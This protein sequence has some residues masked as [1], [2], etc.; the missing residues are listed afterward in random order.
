MEGAERNSALLPEYSQ[1]FVGFTHPEVL[2]LLGY[3]RGEHWGRTEEQGE[4][5][6]TRESGQ[7]TAAPVCVLSFSDIHM[8]LF[9]VQ[10]ISG[11]KGTSV[12]TGTI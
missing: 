8:K 3:E 9:C 1:S 10:E 11:F 5:V 4:A 7:D 12:L 6:G 2:S